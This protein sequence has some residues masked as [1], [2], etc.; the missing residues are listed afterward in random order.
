MQV[1]ESFSDL[2]GKVFNGRYLIRI[3]L[4]FRFGVHQ[5]PKFKI[6]SGTENLKTKR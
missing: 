2:L 6:R 1:E 5:P 4:S 3:N